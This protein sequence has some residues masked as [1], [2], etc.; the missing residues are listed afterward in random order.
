MV[1]LR[2]SED[3]FTFKII[4]LLIQMSVVAVIPCC[5]TT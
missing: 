5:V 2:L 4:P 3:R 1:I